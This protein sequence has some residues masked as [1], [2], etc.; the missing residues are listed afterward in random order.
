MSWKKGKAAYEVSGISRR[1][2]WLEPAVAD[3]ITRG[4]ELQEEEEALSRDFLE[5]DA[6]LRKAYTTG[7]RKSILTYKQFCILFLSQLLGMH[8]EE[9]AERLGMS[10]IA[11]RVRRSQAKKKLR[12]FISS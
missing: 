10:I 9:I 1:R 5:I 11:V 8:D 6:L 2:S 4:L 7:N 3:A 12:E